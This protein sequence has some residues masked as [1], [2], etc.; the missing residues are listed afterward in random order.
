M[1][2]DSYF[3]MGSKHSVCQDYTAN[4][5]LELPN[6]TITYSIVCDGCS[7][8][9]D[10]DFGARLLAK[11]AALNI[12]NINDPDFHQ[13]VISSASKHTSL[14]GLSEYSLDATLLVIAY[15]NDMASEP[16]IV[17]KMF[18]DGVAYL[19]FKNDTIIFSA[20][21]KSGA[22]YYLNY[23]TNHN[24]HEKFKQ[25]FGTTCSVLKIIESEEDGIITNTSSWVDER[26]SAENF[27]FAAI[28]S[29]GLHSYEKKR[30]TDTYITTENVLFY[31]VYEKL[32]AFKGFNGEF[33]KRRCERSIKEFASESI[34]NTDDMSV[35]VI[36]I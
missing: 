5:T 29:D 8:S 28:T 33:V 4:G 2:S 11:A 21:Y 7:G 12:A 17:L 35:G 34:V 30:K 19:K 9:P 18:G 20:E 14:I 6:K 15:V 26:F 25:A 24:R 23:L 27:L 22:P 36:S 1:H 16:Y 31:D 13:T 10:T 3:W 32:F